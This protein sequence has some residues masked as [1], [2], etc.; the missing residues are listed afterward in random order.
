M[1]PSDCPS[2]SVLAAH[3]RGK[4]DPATSSKV[5]THLAACE[6]CQLAVLLLRKP[7]AFT[8]EGNAMNSDPPIEGHLSP[9]AVYHFI[10]GTLSRSQRAQVEDHLDSCL[11]CVRDVAAALGSEKP[12]SADEEAALNELPAATPA[13]ILARLRPR[14]IETS[15]GSQRKLHWSQLRTTLPIAAAVAGFAILFFAVQTYI[16]A[17]MSSRR[18]VAQATD[19]LIAIRQ[20]TGRVPLRYIPGFQR[21]QVTRSGFD[22]ADPEEEAIEAEIEARFRRAIALAPREVTARLALGLFLLD[23]GRLSEAETELRE[24]WELAPDSVAVAVI[25]GMAVLYF[26]KALREPNEA[27]A[28]MREGLGLLQ[29]ARGIEP[30]NLMVLYNLAVFYQEIGSANLAAQYWLSYLAQDP[31]SEWSQVAQENLDLLRGR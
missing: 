1:S 23:A 16:I 28:L 14:I 30:E 17:P 2:P 10:E 12:P 13:E 6:R 3:A 8:E 9:E 15:P 20:G 11:D 19:A 5:E 18:L 27:P 29:R 24:A 26:E 22:V 21:A 25:N 7:S 31:N 4:L